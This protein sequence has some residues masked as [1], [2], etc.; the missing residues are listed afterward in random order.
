MNLTPRLRR[1]RAF[2]LIELLVVIA[3]IAILIGLLLPAVQ[4]VREAAAR[5]ACSNNL[6]QLGL[7]ALNYESSYG[8]LPA[9]FTVDAT[10]GLSAYPAVVHGWGI[11]FLPYIEQ[12]N[13][14]SQYNFK[15]P[16]VDT[17]FSNNVAVISNY[18]KI[19]NCP[20][21]PRMGTTFSD[22]YAGFPFSASVA[23]YAPDDGINGG[24]SLTNFG[25][26]STAT[27]QVGSAMRPNIK[28]P[29]AIL[30]AFGVVQST[31]NTMLA[32]TDGTSN[33]ILLS[34]DAGRPTHYVNGQLIPNSTSNG[35]GWGDLQ[36]EYGLD[37]TNPVMGSNGYW[38]DIQPGSCVINCSN[39]NE[40]YSFHTGGAN[41]VM[42]DG[43]VQFI[44]QSIA[45]RVYAALVT[46]AGGGLIPEETSPSPN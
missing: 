37:G 11:Y 3:I 40:T 12:G 31:Q 24:S 26:P 35:F 2:T 43:S 30:A 16:F 28:G 25:Y 13:I 32:V 34:E 20:S 6:K 17:H 29:A 33:T 39:D 10:P 38:Q 21:T 42:S 15:Q 4:K 41:H 7:A 14:Y 22:T 9:S 46:A 45:P 23:D 44:K 19:M 27:L 8:L 36:S 18:I 5:M 1:R